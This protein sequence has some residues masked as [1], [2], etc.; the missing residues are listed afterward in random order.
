VVN[1]PLGSSDNRPWIAPV[2]GDDELNRKSG[3]SA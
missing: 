2:I 1:K 3:N